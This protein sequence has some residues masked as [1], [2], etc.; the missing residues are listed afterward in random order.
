[1]HFNKSSR[2]ASDYL[3]GATITTFVVLGIFA[4]V[5]LV[6]GQGLPDGTRITF[7][8]EGREYTIVGNFTTSR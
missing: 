3:W 6:R 1:M 8:V 4:L 2:S 5:S 7:T